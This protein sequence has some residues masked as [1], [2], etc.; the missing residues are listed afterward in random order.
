MKKLLFS[1][2][3]FFQ[4]DLFSQKIA[5][6]DIDDLS[7]QLPDV[8]LEL[9]KLNK[10]KSVWVKDLDQRKEKYYLM[11]ATFEDTKSMMAEELIATKKKELES[12]YK[13][14]QSANEQYFGTNGDYNRKYKENLQMYNTKIREA[15]VF[16]GKQN[17]YDVVY[18]KR[19]GELL[20]SSPTADIT[21]QVFEYLTP[22]PQNTAK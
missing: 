15:I 2:I 20:Y 11:K 19:T 4:A 17:G 1:A 3:I 10:L 16:L 22:N 14:W 18:E 12:L 13:D 5:F 8:R 6:V 9:A 7:S 21:G